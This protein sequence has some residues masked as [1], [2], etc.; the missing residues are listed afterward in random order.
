[1]SY[2]NQKLGIGSLQLDETELLAS[3]LDI[4]SSPIIENQLCRRRDILVGPVNAIDDYGSYQ[5]DK[6]TSDKN[7]IF[8]PT[9]RLHGCFSIKIISEE[10]NEVNATIEDFRFFHFFF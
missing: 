1:M 5:I 10:G 2:T 9:F 7:Y 8:T 6:K 3:C 4:F